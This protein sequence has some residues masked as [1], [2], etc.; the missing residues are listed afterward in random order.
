MEKDFSLKNDPG[1]QFG[2]LRSRINGTVK[3]MRDNV[4]E[5]KVPQ[6]KTL[7]LIP[8]TGLSSGKGIPFKH[9]NNKSDL[10]I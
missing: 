4:E 3:Q 2:N 9:Y 7:P 6:G 5:M 10:K 8:V 1:Y